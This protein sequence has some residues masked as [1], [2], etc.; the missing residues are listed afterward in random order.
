MAMKWHPSDDPNLPK[1][2]ERVWSD[3]RDVTAEPVSTWPPYP[4]A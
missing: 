2:W 3:A 1:A 4:R